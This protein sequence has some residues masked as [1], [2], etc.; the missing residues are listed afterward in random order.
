[1]RLIALSI[2]VS[3]SQ[4][5]TLRPVTLSHAAKRQFVI[6][7][8]DKFD[9]LHTFSP[10]SRLRFMLGNTFQISWL[11][12]PCYLRMTVDD[13]SLLSEITVPGEFKADHTQNGSAA[14]YDRHLAACFAITPPGLQTHPIFRTAAFQLEFMRPL[15]QKPCTR[16]R[17]TTV[18]PYQHTAWFLGPVKR[19]LQ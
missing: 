10:H 5:S 8:R 12:I 19:N 7:D 6:R 11:H 17:I 4:T 15:K 9:I 3:K 1:M 14:M 13:F 2:T 16:I 18:Q